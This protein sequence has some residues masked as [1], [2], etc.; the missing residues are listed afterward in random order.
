MA[1]I[2]MA[3]GSQEAPE[4]T[5]AAGKSARTAVGSRRN[6]LVSIAVAS[7]RVPSRL[8]SGLACLLLGLMI[9]LELRSAGEVPSF[10]GYYL[11]PISL[12][13][14]FGGMQSAALGA[15][16]A[17]VVTL[18]PTLWRGT[19]ASGSVTVILA[20][21]LTF[22]AGALVARGLASAKLML[23]FIHRGSAWRAAQNPR[24][25]GRHLLVVP[26]LE[27][28]L[29]GERAEFDPNLIPL[30][31]QPG[32]A[33]GTSSHPTTRMCLEL[34]EH[35]L[36]PGVTVLDVGCGTGILAIAAAKM[37]ATYVHAIDIDPA[38][39]QVARTNVVHNLVSDKVTVQHGSLDAFYSEGLRGASSIPDGS[40]PTRPPS[41][42]GKFDLILANVLAAV[43]REFIQTGIS[44]LL[45]REGVLIV[46][47]IRSDE[48]ESIQSEFLRSDLRL[49]QSLEK[50]GWCALA[51]RPDWQVHPQSPQDAH[52]P[53]NSMKAATRPAAAKRV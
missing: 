6:S 53:D 27:A 23:D 46:S 22:G 42:T 49:D 35:Y 36:R 48:L 38:A 10:P 44:H 50:D 34:L 9:Y 4:P 8:G 20:R 28:D 19:Q 43:V 14:W 51:A 26:V 41:A 12:L 7:E 30:Y 24:R 13:A 3:I 21:L 40:S 16:A 31:I 2:G 52:P 39:V 25:I 32:M 11:L 1:K 15:A 17:F 29:R 18:A 45:G 37:G 47:G 5:A 33:F